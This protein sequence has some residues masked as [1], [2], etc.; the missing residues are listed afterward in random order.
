AT[1][2]R[3]C[4]YP[5]K[6]LSADA[7]ERVTLTAGRQL[8]HDRRFAIARASSRIDTSDPEWMHKTKFHTLLRDEKLAQLTTAYDPE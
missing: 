6:G 7:L 3:I 8:P 2:A 1:L 5:V 4:R